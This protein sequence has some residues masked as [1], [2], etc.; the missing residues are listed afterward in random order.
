M[1][2]HIILTFPKRIKIMTCINRKKSYWERLQFSL[3]SVRRGITHSVVESDE[4]FYIFHSM[5][6][7]ML[8]LFIRWNLIQTGRILLLQINNYCGYSCRS[9]T[10]FSNTSSHLCEISVVNDKYLNENI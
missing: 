7:A 1:I 4:R 10:S 8:N 3:L 2:H 6:A 9:K 5:F